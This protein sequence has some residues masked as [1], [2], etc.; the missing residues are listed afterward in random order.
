M[1]VREIMTEN[2]VCCTPDTN[3]QEVARLMLDN[4]CGLIPVVDNQESKKPIGTITDRDVTIRTVATG[5][6][7]LD[8]KASNIMTMGV[9]TVT[10]ETSVQECC[11]VMENKKIRRVLVVDENGRCCGIVAQAD[12]AEYGNADLVSNM[13]EEISESAPTPNLGSR[14]RPRSNQSYSAPPPPMSELSRTRR[15][16]SY[17]GNEFS[18]RSGKNTRFKSERNLSS[19]RKSF[20]SIKSFIPLLVGIGTGAALKY[21]IIPDNQPK[22]R[23]VKRRDISVTTQNTES[24]F[25]KTSPD[26]TERTGAYSAG[27]KDVVTGSVTSSTQENRLSTD[28]DSKDKDKPINT[29]GIGRSAS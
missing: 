2:P 18:L 3:L 27:T 7:P 11:D 26:L 17:S 5:Q 22:Q 13:V 1:Q 8:V 16:Q 10:P 23:P 24:K 19:T 20:F 14:M 28:V 29:T 25:N 4:D 6:N 21:F 15:N 9:S 12:V